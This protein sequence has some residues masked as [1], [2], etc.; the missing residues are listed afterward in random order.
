MGDTNKTIGVIWE[1]FGASETTFKT[2]DSKKK[3]L[4]IVDAV[5]YP[6]TY[7]N[8]EEAGRLFKKWI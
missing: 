2:S 4:P 6:K 3:P 8:P 7:S 1:S 5:I